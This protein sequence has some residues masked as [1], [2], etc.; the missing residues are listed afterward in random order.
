M[1]WKNTRSTSPERFFDVGVDARGALRDICPTLA[2]VPAGQA[3]P[4][5]P[6]MPMK[7]L[8]I[9]AAA[10]LAAATANAQT[11][12][13][14][15]FSNDIPED[16]DQIAG[17]WLAQGDRGFSV[18]ESNGKITIKTPPAKSEKAGWAEIVSA[19][20]NPEMDFL[21]K[22]VT[23]SADIA[24]LSGT[25]ID[26]R[27]QGLR[28]SVFSDN[29]FSWRSN[30]YF[31]IEIMRGHGIWFTEKVDGAVNILVGERHNESVSKFSL[32]LDANGYQLVV[33]DPNGT[34]R[35][36]EGGHSLAGGT[37]NPGGPHV[38]FTAYKNKDGNSDGATTIAIDNFKVAA[39]PAR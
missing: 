22:P 23:F 19:Q 29:D 27:K 6:S 33:T 11:L 8:C 5:N 25:T 3:R 14:D 36:F 18:T 13:E 17:Y 16:S 20:P 2:P 37:W 31:R 10:T 39:E 34:E 7:T 28:L 4:H 21:K 1:P 38:G 30:N 35:L 12:F 15:T 32:T 9:L 26:K 24:D